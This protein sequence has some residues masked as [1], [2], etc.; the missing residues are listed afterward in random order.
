MGNVRAR[1]ITVGVCWFAQMSRCQPL[2]EA[3][4]AEASLRHRLPSSS[5]RPR[6]ALT[7]AKERRCTSHGPKALSAQR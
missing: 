3:A 5:S 6:Q 1:G 4:Q 7:G 2:A